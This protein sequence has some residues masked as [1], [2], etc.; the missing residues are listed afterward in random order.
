MILSTKFS[1]NE[2]DLEYQ[3]RG[4]CVICKNKAN[5]FKDKESDLYFKKYG[6]CQS[7]QDLIYGTYPRDKTSY[8]QL[9]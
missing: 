1:K 9:F 2:F 8:W 7:C 5:F 6:V 4:F 3:S